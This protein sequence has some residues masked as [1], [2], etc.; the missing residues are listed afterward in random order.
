M[1]SC[2]RVLISSMD[3]LCVTDLAA[4]I[5]PSDRRLRCR[6]SRR[7]DSDVQTTA[8]RSSRGRRAV[9]LSEDVVHTHGHQILTQRAVDAARLSHRHTKAAPLHCDVPAHRSQCENQAL[10]FSLVPTPSVPDTR[11]GSV[12]PAAFRSK[13]PAKP[14]SSALQPKTQTHRVK[15][16][17]HTYTQSQN[18]THK[19]AHVDLLKINL[20]IYRN[21]S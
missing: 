19:H 4:H 12:N 9:R 14:P 2:S 11:M 10:T 21:N 16:H 5:R 17:T 8:E 6:R 1:K 20:L 3:L 15:N 13:R 18:H 7:R